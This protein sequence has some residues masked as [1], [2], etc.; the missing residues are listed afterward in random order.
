MCRKAT[1]LGDAISA[2]IYFGWSL[3]YLFN[4]FSSDVRDVSSCLMLSYIRQR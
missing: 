1:S 2:L 3:N 4:A